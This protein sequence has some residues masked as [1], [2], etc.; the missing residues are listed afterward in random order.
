MKIWILEI[1]EPLPLEKDVRLHRYGLFSRALAQAGHTVTWWT[2]SFSHAPKTHF[3]EHDQDL[4]IDDVHLKMIRGPGYTRNVSLARIRHNQH[5]AQRFRELAPTMERPD[6]ILSPIPIIEAAKEAVAFARARKIAV[7]TDI[8]DLWPEELRDRA[9]RPLRWFAR[10]LLTRAYRSMAYVCQNVTGIMGIA[11]TYLQYGLH[12]AGR[13]LGPNDLFFPLGYSKQSVAPEKLQ[14][15]LAWCAEQ[16][17]RETRFNICFF[18]TIGQFFDLDT[19]IAAA[20]KLPEM[21]FIIAGTG[22]DLERVR[23]LG[24]ECKNVLFPGWLDA[25]K[26]QAVMRLSKVGLAPYRR[27]A[28]MALPNKPFEYMAG[29]LPLLSSIARELPE[30]LS[31]YECGRSYQA[32][33]VDELC[34]QLKWFAANPEARVRM[35][36]NAA[37]LLDEQFATEKVFARIEQELVRIVGATARSH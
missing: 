32:N 26:I 35:G 36:Q 25:P 24:S 28:N 16:G 12:F 27:G 13:S 5:F 18:G 8:R 11:E 30:L 23:A 37:R 33:S 31:K 14:E 10:L 22:S 2:S 21:Q 29:G 19:V 20:R 17:L 15:A 4:V 1:G 7:L 9:P 34:T 3:A 6:L